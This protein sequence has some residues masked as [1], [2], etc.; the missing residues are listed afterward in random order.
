[1]VGRAW[2]PFVVGGSI[3]GFSTRMTS[4]PRSA[5][6]M[7]AKGPD[8]TVV[9]STTLIPRSGGDEGDGTLSETARAGGLLPSRG[10]RQAQLRRNILVVLTAARSEAPE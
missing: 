10:R 8:Q 6:S 7:V 9:R 1:M 4:A 5:S 3:Q 2:Y